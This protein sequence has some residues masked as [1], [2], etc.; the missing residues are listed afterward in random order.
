MKRDEDKQQ[1]VERTDFQSAF[2]PLHLLVLHC[3]R[4]QS[5]SDKEP[6]VTQYEK[7]RSS[8]GSSELLMN[9]ILSLGKVAFS[10]P[11]LATATANMRLTL[12]TCR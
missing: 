5:M 4:C 7:P 2:K 12:G 11:A 1:H 8:K 6:R 9:S 3:L 10:R